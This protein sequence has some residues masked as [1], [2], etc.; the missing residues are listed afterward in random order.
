MSIL[1]ME[2]TTKKQTNYPR[3]KNKKIE[4]EKP[5]GDLDHCSI[6]SVD[7]FKSAIFQ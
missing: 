7:Y 4:T 3:P 1:Q 6:E 2:K 5:E